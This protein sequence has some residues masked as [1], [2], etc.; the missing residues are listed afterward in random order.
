MSSVGG[1]G[2]LSFNWKQG[3]KSRI[4]YER[5]GGCF[6]CGETVFNPGSVQWVKELPLGRDGEKGT[7]RSRE[8]LAIYVSF[9]F[10]PPFSAFPTAYGSSPGIESDLWHSCSNAGSLTHRAGSEIKPAMPQTSQIINTLCHSGTSYFISLK[11]I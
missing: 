6:L 8:S 11:K 5:E 4:T 1:E 2:G 10:F 9:L 3:L 7:E